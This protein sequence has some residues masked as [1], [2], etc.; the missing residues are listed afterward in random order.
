[1]SLRRRIRLTTLPKEAKLACTA[2]LADTLTRQFEQRFPKEQAYVHASSW[3]V[4]VCAR[5]QHIP[6]ETQAACRRL[7]YTV[8]RGRWWGF[9]FILEPRDLMFGSLKLIGK[10]SIPAL[11][12]ARGFVV[13]GAGIVAFLGGLVAGISRFVYG[14]RPML[15][16]AL[17]GGLIFIVLGFFGLI[18]LQ[19]LMWIFA[20][21]LRDD[22]RALEGPITVAWDEV[23]EKSALPV[24]GLN[25]EW[26]PAAK[27]LIVAV[28]A[29]TA[30]GGC[31]WAYQSFAEQGGVALGATAWVVIPIAGLLA[32][33]ALVMLAM[34]ALDLTD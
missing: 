10:A 19:P 32:A 13:G 8:S 7:Q 22:V 11:G 17:F 25:E 18:L 20:H 6:A 4:A 30:G 2:D 3:G 5:G 12:T 33:A 28:S 26:S 24:I 21:R 29:T 27:W 31:W 9:R 1:M 15:T 23:R 34:S 16:G 14:G